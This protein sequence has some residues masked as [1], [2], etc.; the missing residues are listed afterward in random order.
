MGTVYLDKLGDLLSAGVK[1]HLEA[2][3]A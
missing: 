2:V 3:P 1:R